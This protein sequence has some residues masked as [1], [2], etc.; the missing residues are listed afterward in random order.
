MAELLK[1]DACRKHAKV[2]RP[3]NITAIQDM[4][5][6]VRCITEQHIAS[7]AGIPRDNINSILA[8]DLVMIQLG[9]SDQI[10]TMFR[11]NI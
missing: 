10:F 6:G 7:N 2:N 11:D 9:P 8:D 5:I 3:E 4:V 1:M